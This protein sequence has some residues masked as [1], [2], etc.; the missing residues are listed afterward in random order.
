M[1]QDGATPLHYA[2]SHASQGHKVATKALVAVEADVHATDKVRVGEGFRVLGG[3]GGRG[4]L[5]TLCHYCGFEV[6]N[7]RFMADPI[8][9]S[10]ADP[11]IRNPKP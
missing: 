5:S 8:C 4:G 6:W 11:S 10:Q 3:R 7:L 1:A 9:E 2:A